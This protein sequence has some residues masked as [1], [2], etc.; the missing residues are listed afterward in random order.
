MKGADIFLFDSDTG[1]VVDSYV[2]DQ[3]VKPLP[4][5]CQSWKL[6]DS[7]IGNEDK[8]YTGSGILAGRGRL[9][10]R[11]TSDCRV[12]RFGHANLPRP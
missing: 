5:D 9:Y 11:L 8:G 7:F 6:V 2:L 10:T 1:K 12:G 4:D 3:N